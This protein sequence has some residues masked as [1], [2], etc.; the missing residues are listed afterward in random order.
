MVFER[1][2]IDDLQRRL[3]DAERERDALRRQRAADLRLL[4]GLGEGLLAIDRERRIVIANRR[5][6][7]LF[8]QPDVAGRPLREV[9]R[10]AS[11]FEAFDH[12]LGGNESTVRFSLPTGDRKI[13]MRALPLAFETMAAVALF[14]DVT[15]I[16]HLEQARRNFVSDFS[17]E[18]RTPLA[19]LRSAV[20][21]FEASAGRLSADDDRNLRRIMLRQ[22]RRLERLVDDLSELSRIESGE[23]TLDLRPIELRRVIDDLVEDFAEQAAQ[24]GVHF[25][26]DGETTVIADVHRISQAFSNLIDNAIKYGGDGHPVTIRI[27]D[28]ADAGVV[29]ITDQGEGI[30]ASEREK[31]FHRFYRIDKS[32]SQHAGTGLGLSIAKH[33]VLQHRGSIEVE[34]TEG[35]GSTFMV[36]IP[37]RTATPAG[38]G[39]ASR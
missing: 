10:I 25:A 37:K 19:G 31:I 24:H 39:E 13:E 12:A 4:D 17:H 35:S 27:G 1:R 21:T 34:S 11:V 7:E 3:D 2:K 14:I 20:E 33:L 5:F 29:R 9:L 30:P 22:L 32:R 38:R 36:R 18:V 15:A 8:G 16:E 23:V 28:E 26:V 6:A